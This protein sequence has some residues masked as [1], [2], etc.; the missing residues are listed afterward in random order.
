MLCISCGAEMRLVQVQPDDTMMVT[1]YEHQTFLCLGCG[2][3]ERR[4]TFTREPTPQPGEP[5]PQP[6]EPAPIDQ[7]APVPPASA[8]EDTA[9]PVSP[10]AVHHEDMPLASAASKPQDQPVPPGS[11]TTDQREIASP[12]P[13]A[14]PSAS[15]WARA[16]AKLRDWQERG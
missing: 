16:V 3:T 4:L 2:E 10:D 7:A 11:P 12:N 5:M 9:P 13:S 14:S 8:S 6:G 15:R 1:G